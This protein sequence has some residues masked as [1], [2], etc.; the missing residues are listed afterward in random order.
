MI[1]EFRVADDGKRKKSGKLQ[2]ADVPEP[3]R[4]YL[5]CNLAAGLPTPEEIAAAIGAGDVAVLL[6]D[7]PEGVEPDLKQL[8]AITNVAQAEGVA[9]LARDRIELV[10]QLGLDGVHLSM[11][12]HGGADVARARAA[13]GRDSIVGASAGLSRHL[14]M[15]LAELGADYVGIETAAETGGEADPAARA[16]ELAGQ[17]EF[18]GWWA[19]V[20]EVPGVAFGAKSP[21][22]AATLAATGADFIALTLLPG[23]GAS[24]AAERVQVFDAAVQPLSD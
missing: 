14:A 18:V 15:T 20:I 19:E 24:A 23:I 21:E 13:L 10:K 8:A 5:V 9:V 3:C 12:E 11:S 2:A 7:L 16:L 4:L 6:I 22:T 1:G 17:L